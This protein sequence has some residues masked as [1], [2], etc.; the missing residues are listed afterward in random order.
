MSNIPEVHYVDPHSGALIFPPSPTSRLADENKALKEQLETHKQLLSA[1]VDA[2]PKSTKDK[3]P[4]DLL[5]GLS[6][7]T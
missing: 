2:L 3:L 6:N 1:L 5:E 7:G 4:S